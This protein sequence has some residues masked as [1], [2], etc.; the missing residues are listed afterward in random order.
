MNIY[1]NKHS[2]MPFFAFERRGTMS[3]SLNGLALFDVH[4]EK[5]LEPSNPR[6]SDS[7]QRNKLPHGF[8]TLCDGRVLDRQFDIW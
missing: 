8:N 7:S 1:Q 6:T 2:V 3:C 4:G 5:Y